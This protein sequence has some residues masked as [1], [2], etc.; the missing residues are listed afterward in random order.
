LIAVRVSDA[1]EEELPP[2]GLVEL[3][4]A[5]TGKHLL[6]DTSSRRVREAYR[7]A[8]VER[9]ESLRQLANTAGVDLIEVSTDGSHLDALIRFFQMR[10]RRS[11]RR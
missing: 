9:R 1:R 7:I 8:A 6:L 5:E 11:R 3:E 2:I 4:D 10:E